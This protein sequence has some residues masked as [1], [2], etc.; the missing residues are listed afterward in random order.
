MRN[1][2]A[3]L[4]DLELKKEDLENK[5]I[6]DIGAGTREFA[7]DI[8]RSGISAR[9]FSLDP[10]Y[11]AMEGEVK[12]IIKNRSAPNI[13]KR[14]TA[15][16]GEELPFKDESFDLVISE[17]SLPFYTKSRKDLNDFFSEINRVTKPGGEVRIFGLY[18]A[19]ES[20]LFGMMKN[21]FVRREIKKLKRDENNSVESSGNL[22]IFKKKP[23]D[24][25]ED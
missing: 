5:T 14:T 16:F 6:L 15:G 1:M 12:D 20:S 17:F 13:E 22:L 2:E 7:K 9:V 21:F 18:T 25:A 8:E 11:A 19:S 10:F 4:E 23:S 3:Y 24:A